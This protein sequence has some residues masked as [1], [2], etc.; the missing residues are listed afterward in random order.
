MLLI[1]IISVSDIKLCCFPKC[2]ATKRGMCMQF[3]HMLYKPPEK[4][5]K[6]A[7]YWSLMITTLIADKSNT[8]KAE[9]SVV[10]CQSERGRHVR[11][12]RWAQWGA[13][14]LTRVNILCESLPP[15][16]SLSSYGCMVEGIQWCHCLPFCQALSLSLQSEKYQKLP[17]RLILKTMHNL[18][19]SCE[20]KTAHTLQKYFQ[21]RGKGTDRP[22]EK[23][24]DG[25]KRMG[26]FLLTQIKNP[27]Q[28][29]FKEA[30]WSWLEML[31]V[32]WILR[33]TGF[34]SDIWDIRKNLFSLWDHKLVLHIIIQTQKTKSY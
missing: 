1:P 2:I 13:C 24:C 32:L 8:I 18:F 7:I 26:F 9:G 14:G 10:I 15:S 25:R 30:W 4:K 16:L 29:A 12:I 23:T 11:V 5:R 3:C 19:E 33:K 27:F 31:I 22:S 21:S 6:K 28:T 20:N 17:L 34:L